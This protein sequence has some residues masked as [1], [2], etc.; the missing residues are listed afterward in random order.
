MSNANTFPRGKEE[1]CDLCGVKPV[2]PGRVGREAPDSPHGS[3]AGGGCWGLEKRRNG[4][5]GERDKRG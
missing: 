3:V 5:Q 4:Q 2:R 1:C